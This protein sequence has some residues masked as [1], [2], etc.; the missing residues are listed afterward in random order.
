MMFIDDDSISKG[1]K[2]MLKKTY[3]SQ[4]YM[5]ICSLGRSR[6]IHK[7]FKTGKCFERL[8]PRKHES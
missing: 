1:N 7:D 5:M 6:S 2:D 4:T 8:K 3:L